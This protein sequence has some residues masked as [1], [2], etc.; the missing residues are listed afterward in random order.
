MTTILFVVL[1]FAAYS[2][3]YGFYAPIARGS[4]DRFMLSL[5]L[6]LT[7]SFIWGA[8]SIV[9]RLRRRQSSAWIMRGYLA[10]QWMLFCA[11]SWRVFE[12]LRSP[13]FYN[14]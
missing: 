5:Y 8:E 14:G 13:H 4:G 11:L 12:I 1:C 6:P 7:F 10:A 9:R 2:A 3:A